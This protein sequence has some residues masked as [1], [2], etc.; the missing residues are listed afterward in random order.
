MEVLT[1]LGGILTPFLISSLTDTT[2]ITPLLVLPQS[3]VNDKT[4]S[5]IGVS[6]TI[7]SFFIRPSLKLESS[8][9]LGL[10]DSRVKL[11][12]SMSSYSFFPVLGL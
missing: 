12:V 5:T 6:T 3:F 10:L 8:K 11:W 9:R 4:F 2:R 7:L 1:F